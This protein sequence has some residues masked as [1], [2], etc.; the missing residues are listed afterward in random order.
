MR[1]VAK[2]PKSQLFLLYMSPMLLR[3]LV[4]LQ[5]IAQTHTHI[6]VL[7]FN[8]VACCC[9]L[10]E[11]PCSPQ[12]TPSTGCTEPSLLARQPNLL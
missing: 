3:F 12:R 2:N 7:K 4:Q 6:H 11:W 5:H 10:N 1:R 8:N 9:L